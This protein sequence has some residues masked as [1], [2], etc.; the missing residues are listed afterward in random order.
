MILLFFVCFQ[1]NPHGI[2]ILTEINQDQ[3]NPN[4]RNVF[5]SFNLI[6]LFQIFNRSDLKVL[7]LSLHRIH[8]Q[9]FV[10]WIMRLSIVLFC[11]Y[12]REFILLHQNLYGVIL[13]FTSQT[14]SDAVFYHF[15]FNIV[16]NGNVTS[17]RSFK[18]HDPIFFR[19]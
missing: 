19:I 16:L 1:K 11:K 14:I 13:N 10:N 5:L 18:S 17:R 15:C 8:I 2:Q 12:I 6:N 9:N 4:K 7:S 3:I